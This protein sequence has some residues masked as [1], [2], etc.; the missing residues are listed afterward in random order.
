MTIS[1]FRAGETFSIRSWSRMD[2]VKVVRKIFRRKQTQQNF[3]YVGAVFPPSEK[4]VYRISKWYSNRPYVPDVI[5]VDENSGLAGIELEIFL[6]PSDWCT[7]QNQPFYRELIQYLDNL[8]T[9]KS[10]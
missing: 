5:T 8:K 10:K 1:C 4:E 2:R 9:L 3:G 7:L 6:E